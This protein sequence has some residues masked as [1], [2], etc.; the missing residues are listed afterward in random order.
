MGNG[1]FCWGYNASGELGDGSTTN[2]VRPV[3]VIGGGDFDQGERRLAVQL[4]D[5]AR[6]GGLLLG[7]KLQRQAG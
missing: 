2:R 4:R 5:R 3:K 6:P 7:R 1:A